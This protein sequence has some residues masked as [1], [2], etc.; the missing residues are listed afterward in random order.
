MD[1]FTRKSLADRFERVC[2]ERGMPMTIQRRAVFDTLLAS[3]DHPTVDDIYQRVSER[4]PG[5]SQATVYRVLE[6]LEDSGLAARI[7]HP[8][9]AS[10]YDAL[11]TL[12]HHLLC[13][14]CQRVVDVV[15]LPEQV[16]PLPPEA[17]RGF[18]IHRC[19][20]VYEGVCPACRSTAGEDT[21]DRGA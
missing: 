3:E 21:P 7:H 13:V 16:P 2:R 4:A 5:I 18:E 19:R 8:G 9:S 12:H 17:A 15:D 14:E 11:T 1:E 20:I 6:L 10:R